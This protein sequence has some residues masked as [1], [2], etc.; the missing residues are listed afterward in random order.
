MLSCAHANMGP[1]K[2][3]KLLKEMVG[4]HCHVG[5]MKNDFKNF[6]RDI[7]TYINEADAQMVINRLKKKK[8]LSP[9]SC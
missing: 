8:E 5:A 7:M 4:G 1:V 9:H 2:S 6:K 3:Y